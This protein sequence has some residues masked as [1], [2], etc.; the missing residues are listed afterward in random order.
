MD[1]FTLTFLNLFSKALHSGA[2]N[3]K[4]GNMGTERIGLLQTSGF[5][6]FSRRAVKTAT[7]KYSVNPEFADYECLKTDIHPWAESYDIYEDGAID[8]TDMKA[9]LYSSH[10]AKPIDSDS[11]ELSDACIKTKT[12]ML[13]HETTWK[14]RKYIAEYLKGSIDKT[15]ALRSIDS[16][17]EDILFSISSKNKQSS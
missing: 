3:T 16:L 2:Y 4:E 12:A 11:E 6:E 7:E 5:F 13:A 8:V 10:I 9:I 17:E 14:L 1:N 15:S